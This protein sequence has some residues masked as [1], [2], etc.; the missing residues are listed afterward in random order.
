M[1]VPGSLGLDVHFIVPELTLAPVVPAMADL[2]DLY[3][4]SMASAH[5]EAA[6]KARLLAVR[7]I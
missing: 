7:T 3:K 5:E 2:I 6:A 4:V 1:L